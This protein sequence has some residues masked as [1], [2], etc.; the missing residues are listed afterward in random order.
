[1]NCRSNDLSV[2]WSFS[3][4]AF[5]QMNFRS[6]ELSVKWTFGQM[7]FRSYTLV[8]NFFSVKWHIFSKVYS[9]KWLFS[10][11][12]NQSY[13]LSVKWTFGQMAYG[14]TMFGQTVFRSNGLSVKKFQWN[15]FSVKWS[16]TD[17]MWLAQLCYEPTLMCTDYMNNLL[18]QNRLCYIQSPPSYTNLFMWSS[19]YN[20]C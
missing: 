14:Q 19:P 11:E 12:K 4:K 10:E 18:F 7:N 20:R 16:R 15:D 3:E 8:C 13:D 9:V 2:K 5:G 6:N 1:M 17:I